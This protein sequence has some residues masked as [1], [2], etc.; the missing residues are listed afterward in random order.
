MKKATL[1]ILITLFA[2]QYATAQKLAYFESNLILKEMPAFTKAN[3]ELDSIAKQW[4]SEIDDK[5]Q[6][7]DQ[8]YKDYVKTESSFSPEVKQQK[9][10]EI[11]QAE[12]Q[13]KDLKDQKFGMDG[14][15]HKL[16]EEK[17]QPLQESINTAAKEIAKEMNYDYVF[18]LSKESNWVY[19]NDDYNITELVKV[20]LGL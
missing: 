7:V 16:Q 17:I 3:K 12:K 5:F 8:L 13:A 15:M 20:K 19:L 11:F 14:E 2:W 1:G 6:Y 10:E 9:Q 18:D 4:E